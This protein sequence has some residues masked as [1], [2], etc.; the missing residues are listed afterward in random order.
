MSAADEEVKKRTDFLLEHMR[1]CGAFKCFECIYCKREE[2]HLG[3]MFKCVHD[4]VLVHCGMKDE[5]DLMRGCACFWFEPRRTAGQA[6]ALRQADI[7]DAIRRLYEY[8]YDHTKHT[9]NGNGKDEQRLA[10]ICDEFFKAGV[11]L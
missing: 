8:A 9:V 10:R 2:T 1:T 6:V 5:Q 4:G 7:M 3:A 11:R